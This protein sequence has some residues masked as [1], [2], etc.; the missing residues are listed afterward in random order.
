MV[1]GCFRYPPFTPQ[2]TTYICICLAPHPHPDDGSTPS[3]FVD[4]DIIVNEAKRLAT[5]REKEAAAKG[6][7]KKKHSDPGLKHL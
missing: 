2:V 1:L 6:K 5:L 3:D 4:G 7:G